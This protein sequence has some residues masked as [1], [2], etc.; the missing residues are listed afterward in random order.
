MT[1][2]FG[3]LLD[4]AATNTHSPRRARTSL[5]QLC[6]QPLVRLVPGQPE[7]EERRGREIARLNQPP[8][9]SPWRMRASPDSM[10]S[11]LM[12]RFVLVIRDNDRL[13]G[14][15]VRRSHRAAYNALSAYVHRRSRQRHLPLPPN[16]REAIDSYFIE[17]GG[18]YV[19]ARLKPR[20]TTPRPATCHS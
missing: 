2:N 10:R 16:D 14:S 15:Y 9:H 8:R 19:I 13:D 12:E 18:E 20:L 1:S 7:V 11:S 3:L 6:L 5:Q 17:R 4:T